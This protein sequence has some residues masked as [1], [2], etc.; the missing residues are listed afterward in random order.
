MQGSNPCPPNAVTILLKNGDSPFESIDGKAVESGCTQ[1]DRDDVRGMWEILAVQ[2]ETIR[3]NAN[4]DM[5]R[6]TGA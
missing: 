3:C 6:H 5:N 4:N 2:S 1:S